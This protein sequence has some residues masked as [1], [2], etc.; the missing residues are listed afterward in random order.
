MIERT[1]EELAPV[2]GTRPG[3]RTLS[4]APAT[5]YR[6]R[7]PIPPAPEP[8]PRQYPARSLSEPEREEVVQVL[9]SMRLVDSSPAQV[10]ATPLDEGRYLC[11]ER[12]MYRR[13][14][15]HQE[16]RERR[17]QLSHPTFAKPE[18]LV[19]QP[20][21]VWSWDITRQ[22]GQQKWTHYYL[23]IISTS[24]G[25]FRPITAR[26]CIVMSIR[27]NPSSRCTATR[28]ARSPS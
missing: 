4:V 22:L 20:N 3:S 12:T 23:Y 7:R 16:V 27:T 1:V 10:G 28:M 24:A 9:R 15:E 13:R 25:I 17:D 11:S 14:A 21:Q 5:I 26:P 6:R 2:V 18:L 8:Q 19:E